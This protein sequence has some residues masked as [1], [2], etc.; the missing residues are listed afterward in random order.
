MH[1][2]IQTRDIGAAEAMKTALLEL[3][4]MCVFKARVGGF[5]NVVNCM[6]TD[7]YTHTRVVG[8]RMQ[9]CA[10]SLVFGPRP[11]NRRTKTKSNHV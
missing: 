4:K 11:S 1:M 8:M 6:C 9:S 7:A 3:M 2:H 10:R 5:R